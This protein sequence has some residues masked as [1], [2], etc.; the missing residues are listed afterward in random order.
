MGLDGAVVAP[1]AIGQDEIRGYYEEADVF[2][3]PSF[4]EGVPVVL[5]EAMALELPVVATRIAGIPELVEDG[6][7]GFVV[8]PGR[9]DLLAGAIRRL[10]GDPHLRRE[11]GRRGRERVLAEFEVNAI[12]PRLAAMFERA[13]AAAPQPE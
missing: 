3:L 6:I 5:M 7:S 2:V 13:I 1:G 4:A 9:A 8:A 11:M 12:A 10:A